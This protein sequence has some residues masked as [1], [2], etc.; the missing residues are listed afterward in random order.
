ME[1]TFWKVFV[2]AKSGNSHI[3]CQHMESFQNLNLILSSLTVQMLQIIQ[4]HN[5]TYRFL[6]CDQHVAF[7]PGSLP[8]W[9]LRALTWSCCYPSVKTWTPRCL[10]SLTQGIPMTKIACDFWKYL[11]Y[12]HLQFL[13]CGASIQQKLDAIFTFTYKPLSAR[14]WNAI[15]RL[16]CK[17]VHATD[18]HQIR[19]CCKGV[20]GA[21]HRI[22]Q[23]LRESFYKQI[24]I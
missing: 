9:L 23:N 4:N 1:G 10:K 16:F 20:R 2:Q 15:L 24:K 22:L 8:G 5:K 3:A 19:L 17:S 11:W 18:C 14:F 7:P 21:L 13:R 12:Y 6:F